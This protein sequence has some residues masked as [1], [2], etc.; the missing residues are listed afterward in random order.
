MGKKFTSETSIF[1]NAFSDKVWEA[2][3]DPALV[4]QYLFGTTVTS[5]WQVGSP[6]TY[7]GVWEGKVYE[8]KGEI[9]ECE[10]GKTLVSTYWS[11]MSGVPD[12]PEN[13]ATVGYFLSEE[14]HG[15]RLKITQDDNK[16][17]ESADHSAENWSM[18][19]DGLKKLL[20]GN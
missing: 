11:S 13:Y 9:L 17:Q 19:L 7:K 2:L 3:T 16:S 10:P 6:I 1:I 15:T 14:N 20:E 12:S 4:K 5:D 8:D 18:V